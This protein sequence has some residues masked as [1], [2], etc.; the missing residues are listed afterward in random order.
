LGIIKKIITFEKL[1]KMSQETT[2][3]NISNV[4]LEMSKTIEHLGVDE[5]IGLLKTSRQKFSTLTEQQ[6]ES[7]QIIVQIVCDC[8][9]ISIS[10][11]YSATRKNNRRYAIGITAMILTDDEGIDISD[12]SYLLK[13]PI[14]LI[15]LY[16]KEAKELNPNHKSDIKILEKIIDINQILTNIKQ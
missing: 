13:K 14:N 16:R 8:F 11:F 9:H 2:N 15:S 1:K 6:K 4:F 3:N 10:D 7:S 5:T 12:V